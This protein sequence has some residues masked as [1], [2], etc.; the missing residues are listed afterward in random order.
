MIF[1]QAA[2]PIENSKVANLARTVN[3][4]YCD[5]CSAP[6]NTSA[7]NIK[8]V[9]ITSTSLT[10]KLSFKD[11]FGFNLA[12]I[13]L[14]KFCT[15]MR[16]KTDPNRNSIPN[17]PDEREPTKHNIYKIESNPTGIPLYKF[18]IIEEFLI[19]FIRSYM[20]MAPNQALA[21]GFMFK[22]WVFFIVS[23]CLYDQ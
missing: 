14:A 23:Q 3:R 4:V 22:Y 21:G 7:L 15:G 5:C 16:N 2:V 12:F 17:I 9:R 8:P 6:T 20:N 1:V 19:L 11:P 10:E 18:N 13:L